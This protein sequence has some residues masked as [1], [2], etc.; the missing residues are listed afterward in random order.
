MNTCKICSAP[1]DPIE[2]K[3]K[4]CGTAFTNEA[5]T[6]QSYI[7]A[8]RTILTNIDEKEGKKSASQQA[9]EGVVAIFKS[10]KSPA[11]Q[12]KLNAI[13]TFAMPADIDN[14][15]QFFMFCHGNASINIGFND[16]AGS[17]EKE[18]WIG[19]AKMAFGQLKLHGYSNQTLMNRLQEYESFY[20]AKAK[21]K[22][23]EKNQVKAALIAVLI[24]LSIFIGFM[25]SK[26]KDDEVSET[27]RIEASVSKIQSLLL[28]KQ[29]EAALIEASNVTWRDHPNIHEAKVK[30]Y[31]GQRELIVNSINQAK[32]RD[33]QSAAPRT[34]EPAPQSEQQREGSQAKL[35][36]L[37]SAAPRTPEP[38]PQSEQQREGSQ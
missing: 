8:L 23:S 14:L 19:K 4:Y 6:G 24:I 11:V 30:Q 22:I 31:D 29:Y 35:R 13:S 28:G 2:L 9:A 20:G 32:L 15:L 1:R 12:S 21:W 34:P 17:V 10:G 33:L 27:Q 18:A 36:D 3:C 7:D 25:A 26:E 37:Q 5:V 38:A 16:E